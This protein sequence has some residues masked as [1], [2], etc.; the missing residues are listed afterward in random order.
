MRSQG[1]VCEGDVSSITTETKKIKLSQD[2]LHLDGAP[3][4]EIYDV[5]VVADENLQPLSQPKLQLR[6]AFK[7]LKSSTSSWAEKY[8]AVELIR[9]M[10]VHHS[11][12]IEVGNVGTMIS[13]SGQ[14]VASLRSSIS[15][16]AIL[17]LQ[18]IFNLPIFHEWLAGSDVTAYNNVLHILMTKSTSGPKFISAI[19]LEALE[20]GVQNVP[21]QILVPILSPL[22]THR[23]LEISNRAYVLVA[24]GLVRDQ[25]MEW[26]IPGAVCLLQRGLGSARP[27]GREACKRS[28]ISIC[29]I[30]GKVAFQ[31][32]VR[33]HVPEE[34]QGGVLCI[35][36]KTRLSNLPAKKNQSS[37]A[38]R[39]S[40]RKVKSVNKAVRPSFREHIKN[41]KMQKAEVNSGAV[42]VDS[43]QLII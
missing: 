32:I 27:Q 5:S 31:K 25:S 3:E 7:V 30:M 10:C 12:V 16:N 29:R 14:G 41:M 43:V 39:A 9:R 23:N 37:G 28:L 11:D 18:S 17:C 20:N 26:D 33:E 36:E 21:M 19:A 1:A 35:V 22:T 2:E 15:R 24:E 34:K 8:T 42:G 40:P 38:L 6:S 13:E 4:G